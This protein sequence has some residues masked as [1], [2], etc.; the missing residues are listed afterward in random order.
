MDRIPIPGRTVVLPA[1]D[2]VPKGPL[3]SIAPS[4]VVQVPIVARRPSPEGR[5][6]ARGQA[7]ELARVGNHGGVFGQFG[8]AA[9]SGRDR[10]AVCYVHIPTTLGELEPDSCIPARGELED[11]GEE[12][13]KYG[14]ETHVSMN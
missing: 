4:M 13:E 10:D 3:R 5:H 8:D 7:I 2:I 6:G 9:G 14:N 12:E 11:M 1:R